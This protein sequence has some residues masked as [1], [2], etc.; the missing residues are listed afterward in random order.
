MNVNLKGTR[1]TWIVIFMIVGALAHVGLNLAQHQHV[2]VEA[3]YT[4]IG[5]GLAAIHAADSKQ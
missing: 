3:T 1:T 2:D 5:A 4:A